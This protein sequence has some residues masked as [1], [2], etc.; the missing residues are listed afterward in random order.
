MRRSRY[1]T[2]FGGPVLPSQEESRP[3]NPEEESGARAIIKAYIHFFEV[4]PDTTVRTG[5][6]E[7]QP[8]IDPEE[9]AQYIEE[10]K[11]SWNMMNGYVT[12]VT[13][14]G[15]VLTGK[16]NHE[17][18]VGGKIPEPGSDAL[19]AIATSFK[20]LGYTK[21]DLWVLGRGGDHF[22]NIAR[23]AGTGSL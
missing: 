19:K 13:K 15:S 11:G 16:T 14:E 23:S 1:D 12:V 3:Y 5:S 22:E 9:R 18:L 17:S 20:T 7:A 8:A 6:G 4:T 10:N 21:K 2:G